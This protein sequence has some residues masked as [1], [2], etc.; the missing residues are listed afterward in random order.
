MDE[1]PFDHLNVVPFIDVMLVL[2]VMVLTTATFVA[3]GRIPVSLPRA[4]QSQADK[5]VA[6]TLELRKGG[7]LAIDGQELTLDALAE[8]IAA[9]P[10]ETSFVIRADKDV[11]LQ[12]FVDVADLLKRAK[13]T[14]VALQIQPRGAGGAKGEARQAP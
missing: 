7:E 4:S 2:L 6:R 3:T 11:A 12:G 10:L 8:K 13:F 5:T 1:E 9:M 14:H